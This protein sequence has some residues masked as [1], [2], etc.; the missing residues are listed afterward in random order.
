MTSPTMLRRVHV[1]GLPVV[2]AD[3]PAA[4]EL[5]RADAAARSGRVYALINGYSAKLRRDE[6]VYG[7]AIEDERTVPLPDGA[8]LAFGARLLRIHAVRRCPGPDLMEAACEL[9]ASEGLRMYLLGGGPGVAEHLRDTLV[10]RHPGLQVAG[11]ATPPFGEW[12]AEQNASLVH[13]VVESGADVLWLGV[14]AP[15]QETWAV[16][17][18]DELSI[19]VVCVGAAF[20]FLSGRK[21]RAPKLLRSLGL[22]WLFRLATEPRRLWKRYLVGNAVFIR[23]LC[24]IG[25]RDPRIPSAEKAG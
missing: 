24:T 11:W 14:S 15:K 7:S 6:A 23:D 3:V 21:P 18:C 5:I 20:D 8:P 19:P 12:S 13:A 17:H 10:A 9:A 16:R 1:A 22:E 25:C 2:D 4:L